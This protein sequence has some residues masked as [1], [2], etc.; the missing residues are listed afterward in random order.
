MDATTKLTPAL[1]ASAQ[2]EY[3]DSGAVSAARVQ[4]GSVT[5]RADYQVAPFSVGAGIKAA[6]GDQQG[7]A[8]VVGVGYHRAPVDVDVTHS[9]PLGGG[10]L[11]PTTTVSARYALNEQV[12]LGV[13]DQLNW[14]TG[15]TAAITLDSRVG[16]TNYA[17]AYDL[18]G[19]GGQGNRAR[20]GVTTT[21]PVSDQ[22]SAGLRGSATYDLGAAQGEVG[23]G[24]DLTYK[25]EGLTAAA[26]TDVTAGGKGFGVVLRGGVSGQ[27]SD[28]LTLT[29]DGLVEF[30][31]GKNGQRAALG[32]AYRGAAVNSLG[33][34]RY[35]NGTLAGGA[36]ELSSTL[37]AEYRQANWAVRGGLDTRTLLNDPGS[38]TIQGN[39]G[40]TYYF[41]DYFGLG[42]W[43][44]ALVQPSTGQS[45]YGMGLE[46]S[47][48]AL[49]GTWL[50]AGY[51]PVGFSGL[52]NT[53]TRQG[54]YLRLDLTLD[55]TLGGLGSA[56]QTDRP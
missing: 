15:N 21:L 44:R 31:A 24:A 2:A 37:A 16:A 38:F 14:R 10:T 43:G 22:L 11:D 33:S 20:F 54:A 1:S 18:P 6:Y 35:V 8:A 34:V 41:T 9:Q 28:Q 27:L 50:T 40:G 48:R 49:P 52:G 17:A 13:T 12:T 3:H 36:P 55:E 56:G 19:S 30:G 46:A 4:G 42:A 5:A 45:Q 39:V 25:A 26:G 32:Y 53:Y 7:V 47:V 51:N 29:A 23:A